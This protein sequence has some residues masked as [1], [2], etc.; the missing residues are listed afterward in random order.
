VICRHPEA[1][2]PGQREGATEEVALT[3][4]GTQG[5]QLRQLPVVLDALGDE[6]EAAA[7]SEVL[8]PRRQRLA[9]RVP[10]HP[11]DQGPSQWFLLPS[12]HESCVGLGGLA[13][14]RLKAAAEA[15]GVHPVTLRRRADEGR[16][17]VVR[18]GG[19]RTFRTEELER[20]MGLA[21][22]AIPR[23]EALYVRVSGTTG[24][25]SSLVAQEEELRAS[26]T[27][28][29]GGVP[30]QCFGFAMAP[31]RGESGPDL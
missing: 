26:S 25:E 28:E 18:P 17:P 20:F 30:G 3:Q 6:P 2:S 23:R 5:A 27:G 29:V 13:F 12:E 24:Q 31:P 7:L 16:V 22:K 11:L 21:P 8:H 15:L 10:F 19:E 14:L 1:A 4:P 9:R